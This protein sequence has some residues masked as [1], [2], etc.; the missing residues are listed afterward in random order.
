MMWMFARL[1]IMESM[2][3]HLESAYERL[4]RWTQS[5]FYEFFTASPLTF[6]QFLL[7]VIRAIFSNDFSHI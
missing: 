3:L 1:E 2:A 4:Y 7:P 5:M 6:F